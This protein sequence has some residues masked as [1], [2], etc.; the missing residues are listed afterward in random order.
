LFDESAIRRA[1]G[2][3][4]GRI[5]LEMPDLTMCEDLPDPKTLLHRLILTA[6]ELGSRRLASV[7]VGQMARRIAEYIET[8]NPYAP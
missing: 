7:R 3:P 1:A 4:S 6:T 5:R 2:N 8:S